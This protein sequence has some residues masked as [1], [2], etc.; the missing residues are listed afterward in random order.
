MNLKDPAT[1]SFLSWCT[2]Q[3]IHTNNLQLKGSLPYRYM[4]CE[5][6][7]NPDKNQNKI[8]LLKVPL[9]ACLV[10]DSHTAL[11]D[12]L[13]FEKM[14][15]E[16]SEFYPYLQML[17]PPLEDATSPLLEIPRFWSDERLASVMNFDQ[18]Q[19]Q[20]RLEA[21]N[22]DKEEETLVDAWALACVKTRTNYLDDGSFAMTPLLDMLNHDA[23]ITTKAQV[24]EGSLELNVLDHSFK[25]GEEVKMC[26]GDLTNL[27]TLT[28]YGFVA[29]NNPCNVECLDVRLIL[30]PKPVRVAVCMEDGAISQDTKAQLRRMLANPA[31]CEG[32]DKES[33]SDFMEPISEGNE[34]EILSFLATELDMAAKE[35]RK[36]A[37]EAATVR[38]DDLVTQ[39]LASRATTFEKG[40]QTIK[41]RFPDLE[42]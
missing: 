35:N 23:T 26:Y 10:G 36:G 3:G 22:K 17:P 6:D 11:A 40:I 2:S 12:R 27:D 16:D 41:E 39:Y 42:Y 37:L 20:A 24:E 19:L 33:L 13:T 9:T 21:D 15:G 4:T 31:E 8:P 32:K 18:G 14:L 30:S 25:A 34:L 38:E 28:I 1:A 5:K 29:D 7:L